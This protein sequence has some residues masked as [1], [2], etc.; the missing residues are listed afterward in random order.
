MN[1]GISGLVRMLPLIRTLLL[2]SLEDVHLHALVEVLSTTELLT[3]AFSSQVL[4][5]HGRE[6][7]VPSLKQEHIQVLVVETEPA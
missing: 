2:L 7:R 1:T 6:E 5:V 3:L 4:M